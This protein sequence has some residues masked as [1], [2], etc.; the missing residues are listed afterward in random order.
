MADS[1]KNV[2]FNAILPYDVRKT[3]LVVGCAQLVAVEVAMAKVIRKI[4]GMANRGITELALIHA[5]S[6]PFLGGLAG[7]FEPAGGLGGEEFSASFMQGAKA[8][9]AVFLA[10]Y[11]ISTGALGF[12]VPKFS[13]NDVL[14]TAASKI[15]TRPLIVALYPKLPETLQKNFDLEN[16]MEQA[17]NAASNL[18]GGR[19]N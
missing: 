13:M 8:V 6:L 1:I 5:V 10:Q 16:S 18:K 4:L 17:Q 3:K 11:L 7:F 12:H 9:P 19:G 2:F 15:L 14:V